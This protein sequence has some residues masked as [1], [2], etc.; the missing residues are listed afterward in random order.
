MLEPPS[1]STVSDSIAG[2]SDGTKTAT[3]GRH[4]WKP[5]N[6]A[7]LWVS[8]FL[9]A[10]ARPVRVL[11]LLLLASPAT[12]VR[13]SVRACVRAS[14]LLAPRPP[15]GAIICVTPVSVLAFQTSS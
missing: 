9:Y 6:C 7:L 2:S 10:A 12:W 8:L 3:R 11:L 13:A 5:G 4:A 15:L 14:F 1:F